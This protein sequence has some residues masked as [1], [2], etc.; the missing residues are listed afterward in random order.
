MYEYFLELVKEAQQCC[1][2]DVC[3][4]SDEEEEVG[5]LDVGIRHPLIINNGSQLSCNPFDMNWM[6]RLN[7]LIALAQFNQVRLQQSASGQQIEV[8]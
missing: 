7:L 3:P 6:V 8:A 5:V 4:G 1:S 2:I